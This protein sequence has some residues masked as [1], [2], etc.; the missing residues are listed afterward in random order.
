MYSD[1]QGSNR[2]A[3]TPKGHLIIYNVT[4]E[5][6]GT[7]MCTVQ[8]KLTDQYKTQN[9][10]CELVIVPRVHDL[11]GADGVELN[12]HRGSE[13]VTV[14]LEVNPAQDGTSLA[15]VDL[16]TIP[17]TGKIKTG[18]RSADIKSGTEELNNNGLRDSFH[19]GTESEAVEAPHGNVSPSDAENINE[20]NINLNSVEDKDARLANP[21]TEQVVN[22]KTT[23]EI[24]V[25]EVSNDNNTYFIHIK[26]LL[27]FATVVVV[28]IALIVVIHFLLRRK[29]SKPTL[30]DEERKIAMSTS[31]AST[32]ETDAS[33]PD[34]SERR[35]SELSDEVFLPD[36]AP[37]PAPI[38][39][40]ISMAYFNERMRSVSTTLCAD[41]AAGGSM[42]LNDGHGIADGMA[43]SPLQ[44]ADLINL[45]SRSSLGSQ[46]SE[47][48]STT[49][50]SYR[51]RFSS[52]Y[53]RHRPACSFEISRNNITL[54]GKI[55]TGHF[56]EVH[57]AILLNSGQNQSVA[58]KTLRAPSTHA[59]KL[60]LVREME[61]M[62]ML[63]SH[64]FV[65]KFIGCCTQPDLDSPVY[66]VMELATHGNLRD[67]LRT[68]RRHHEQGRVTHDITKIYRNLIQFAWQIANGMEFLHRSKFIHRDLAARNILVSAD[69]TCRIADFGLAKAINE[70]EVYEKKSEDPLPVRWMAPESLARNVYTFASDVWSYG[71]LVYEIVTL[72]STPYPQYSMSE[73]RN[74]VQNG[75]VMS[76]PRHCTHDIYSVMK[77]CWQKE[78]GKR[79][80]FSDIAIQLQRMTTNQKQYIRI[81]ELDRSFYV[82][83][84]DNQNQGERL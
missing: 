41:R 71:I 49:G 19:D 77:R 45:D 35:S 46:L 26:E 27:I 31:S 18:D 84:D 37:S 9:S 83:L 48:L 13:E 59:E 30:K 60:N 68:Y 20:R 1:R 11:N 23:A 32:G 3:N 17:V 24:I 70:D 38:S 56:G 64:P 81:S 8:F 22:N 75:Q 47:D 79:P 12:S 69:M 7:Y 74:M 50:G 57:Q 42:T 5:D 72:G 29:R 51:T 44:L 25:K 53:V 6:A 10:L 78:A 16:I 80:R 61:I 15:N 58:V 33:L 36:S 2:Y 66:L 54:C 82:N 39:T 40:P 21:S 28:G 76:K 52:S 65:I 62:K 63:E 43:T 73:V 4:E 34:Q 67:L 14:S 55:G